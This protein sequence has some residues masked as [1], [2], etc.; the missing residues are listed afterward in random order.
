MELMCVT[1]G[2]IWVHSE[3]DVAPGERPSQEK[4]L[5]GFLGWEAG[6]ALY[7]YKKFGAKIVAPELVPSLMVEQE[8][9]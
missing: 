7:L 8:L 9:Q 6:N 3:L 2:E 5:D 4:L 1:Q